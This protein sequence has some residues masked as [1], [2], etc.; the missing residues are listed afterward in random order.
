MLTLVT[1]CKV[2]K[3]SGGLEHV[4]EGKGFAELLGYTSGH[5]HNSYY[6]K[7]MSKICQGRQA[8]RGRERS[9]KKRKRR[10]IFFKLFM[11]WYVT[12]TEEREEEMLTETVHL[13]SK[14][15]VPMPLF[16]A[17]KAATASNRPMSS[18]TLSKRPC[19]LRSS[20]D[21]QTMN[22]ALSIWLYWMQCQ[23]MRLVATLCL[24]GFNGPIRSRCKQD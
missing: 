18:T 4:I 12:G 17:S 24:R 5:E 10:K 19:G 9:A 23:A 6:D 16:R 3:G 1:G 8:T 21:L 20:L 13:P 14:A 11:P 22:P 15:R 2:E 7:N